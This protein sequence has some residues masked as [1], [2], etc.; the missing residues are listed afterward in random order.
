MPRPIRRRTVLALITLVAGLVLAGTVTGAAMATDVAY[1]ALGD[2]YAAGLGAGGTIASTGSC[3]RS[4]KAYPA[5]WRRAHDPASYV[6]RA[7]SG[8]TTED[9]RARQLGALRPETTLVSVTA[10][11][12]DVG[13]GPVMRACATS[14]SGTCVADV[15]AA[16]KTMRTQ[17]PGH[18]DT[19]YAAI[20]RGAPN[21]RVVVVGYPR[22]YH[23]GVWWCLGLTDTA[24]SKI[25]E[26]A[27]VLDRVIA[28]AAS[29]AGFTFADVRP[30][31]VGHEI[32]DGGSSWLHA[33]DFEDLAESYHPTAA[34]QAGG[35]LPP[36]TRTAAGL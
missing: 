9:V 22:L 4:S 24:R 36:F 11:G 8:A 1:V 12:N 35:Y 16:E 10:G 27:N 21:A 3:E 17:L 7:C 28:A 31:F 14:G 13:F 30:A 2:S 29:R 20:R 34:G 33:V 15:D 6:S 25:N 5:L 18:L 23:V 26:A 32:C 19:L